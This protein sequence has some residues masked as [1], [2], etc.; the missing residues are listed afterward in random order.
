MIANSKIS[1][2]EKESAL[3]C[4]C[5]CSIDPGPADHLNS[6]II[7]AGSANG[8]ILFFL[9]Y[10]SRPSSLAD[11]EKA[12]AS[13]TSSGDRLALCHSVVGAFEEGPVSCIE[14]VP[15]QRSVDSTSRAFVVASTAGCICGWTLS[16]VQNAN[17][18]NSQHLVTEKMFSMSRKQLDPLGMSPPTQLFVATLPLTRGQSSDTL[19]NEPNAMKYL[20]HS[21]GCDLHLCTWSTR[22]QPH[23]VFLERES[24]CHAHSSPITGIQTMCLPK[25]RS[26]TSALAKNCISR[27]TITLVTTSL[28]GN[29]KFWQVK[30]C[31]ASTSSGRRSKENARAAESNPV[32]QL[33]PVA[34]LHVGN[35]IFGAMTAFTPGPSTP[36]L[37]VL[38]R[39]RQAHK[40]TALIDPWRK[41]LHS[42]IHVYNIA[43]SSFQ[44]DSAEQEKD[45]EGG[46]AAIEEE[47]GPTKRCRFIDLFRQTAPTRNQLLYPQLF[48]LYQHTLTGLR[49][50]LRNLCSPTVPLN[51]LRKSSRQ[52]GLCLC[53]SVGLFV[54]A[55][56]YERLRNE[57]AEFG[58]A[59]ACFG[60]QQRH[61]QSIAGTGSL[62]PRGCTPNDS[63]VTYELFSM[64][65]MVKEEL[66]AVH[67]QSVE[68]SAIDDSSSAD[69]QSAWAERF[70]HVEWFLHCK[71]PSLEPAHHRRL[72]WISA[73]F[74]VQY[75]ASLLQLAFS[76]L[77][78]V[79]SGPA[80]DAASEQ[81]SS[82][83]GAG[84]SQRPTFHSTLEPE[85]VCDFLCGLRASGL[86]SP[87]QQAE[88]D[89]IL[90]QIPQAGIEPKGGR[91]ALAAPRQAAELLANLVSIPCEP[92]Q[93]L[94][95]FGT[96]QLR[97]LLTLKPLCEDQPQWTCGCGLAVSA[98]SAR[99]ELKRACHPLATPGGVCCPFCS[100][101]FCEGDLLL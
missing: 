82:S 75:V 64:L 11:T 67:A 47:S 20:I 84:A 81:A 91:E 44:M 74:D 8:N 63:P 28:D 25:T 17:V 29:V 92:P 34:V 19:D 72:Q 7:A 89:C 36:F 30:K 49:A 98:A 87:S 16:T 73:E 52:R 62:S 50:L 101:L 35:P 85:P 27:T 86:V 45:N 4:I 21:F 5:W 54:F 15:G 100:T 71:F 58:L 97:C 78:A 93:L 59:V 10:D 65:E 31:G 40:R 42:A 14:F 51:K 39:Q 38:V 53:N 2:S 37:G 6:A 12:H 57:D 18:E 80:P 32:L 99:Q 41:A 61:R 23:V 55:R 79:L 66:S 69:S 46:I 22:V 95:V 88:I 33:C 94:P 24:T 13:K 76:W 83:Q 56:V 9:V 70:E 96:T 43:D 90:H 68:C 1:C 60:S 77:K 48:E 3:T 26:K